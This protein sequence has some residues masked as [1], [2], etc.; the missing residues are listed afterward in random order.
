MKTASK[1]GSRLFDSPYSGDEG[2]DAYGGHY[3]SRDGRSVG[4]KASKPEVNYDRLFR[5][6]TTARRALKYAREERFQAVRLYAGKHYSEYGAE[7]AQPVNLIARYVQIIS[8]S[9]VPNCPQMMLSTMDR[10][11]IPAVAV[12]QD[13]LNGQLKDMGFD[14]ICQRA[15][16]D[17]LFGFGAVKVG[18]ASPDAAA[19]SGYRLPA[20]DPYCELVEPDDFVF[21]IGCTDM[22]YAAFVGHRFQIPLE[23][24]REL[25]YFDDDAKKELS[26]VADTDRRT[27]QEGDE[28]IG[29]IGRGWQ[30]ADITD[31]ERPVELWEIYLSRPKLVCTFAAASGGG[32]PAG[33]TPP[34]AVREWVGPPCGPY[35]FLGLKLI[36]GQPLSGGPV[37]DLVDLHVSV[38]ESYRKLINQMARQKTVLPVRGAQ[39]DDAKKMIAA[40]DGE[41]FQCDNAETAKEISLGGPSQGNATF[42]VHLSDLF[43]KLGGNLDLLSGAAPQSKTAT[44]DKLLAAGAGAGVSDMQDTVTKFIAS[45]GESLCWFWHHHPQKVMKT[46]K[47][48]PGL[49]DIGITRQLYPGSYKEMP[50][51]NPPLKRQGKYA[52]MKLRV[53]PYSLV[54]K[55]P[56]ERLQF[57]L[58]LYD[59][60]APQMQLMAGMGV[61]MDLPFLLK[62]IGE[63]ASEPDVESLFTIAAAIPMQ[64]QGGDSPSPGDGTQDPKT[65]LH[66]GAGPSEPSPQ[67]QLAGMS[68]N[69]EE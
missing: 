45:V 67:D 40:R 1:N 16:I 60:F 62:K 49:P 13:W 46:N 11:Q 3:K 7:T 38:N 31:F 27:N 56:S 33:G 54:F 4:K 69:S 51:E 53:D 26:A 65:Y 50:G 39:T 6:M 29:T 32:V 59:K 36:P 12:E 19:Q 2:E 34:L 8:R 18:I 30:T 17:A 66:R 64:P 42:T 52:D 21:D 28:R 58:S 23:I 10:G 9:L 68:N 37:Q 15:V 20:G 47:T 61:H 48:L 14:G 55:S 25:D 43:N 35:H 24:A 41:A 44:Q 5:A 57:V 22:R 63:Y